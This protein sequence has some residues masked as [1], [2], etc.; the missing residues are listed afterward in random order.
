MNFNPRD[1]VFSRINNLCTKRC[2]TNMTTTNTAWG[3]GWIAS[4]D[5]IAAIIRSPVT[6]GDELVQRDVQGRLGTGY[7]YRS[8]YSWNPPSKWLENSRK[9]NDQKFWIDIPHLQVP[10]PSVL[11]FLA[12]STFPQ[13]LGS[14]IRCHRSCTPWISLVM[15][16]AAA[17]FVTAEG[18]GCKVV[19]RFLRQ[20]MLLIVISNLS[21]RHMRQYHIQYWYCHTTHICSTVPSAWIARCSMLITIQ[22]QHSNTKVHFPSANLPSL[23]NCKAKR[24]VRSSENKI[25]T[26]WSSSYVYWW[27]GIPSWSMIICNLLLLLLWQVLCL[28]NSHTTIQGY[29][30]H[31]WGAI[32]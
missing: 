32:V 10:S 27:I 29:F 26:W 30:D 16:P 21:K 13:C 11:S 22:T 20:K 25:N 14:W 5:R 18:G 9:P 17:R 4:L 12:T 19:V 8:T 24:L 7:R 6:N 31:F 28:K 3:F 23:L 1:D 2:V 15:Q